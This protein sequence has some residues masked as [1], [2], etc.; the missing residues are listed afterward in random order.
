MVKAIERRNPSE[1]QSEGLQDTAIERI[2][3]ISQPTN[4]NNP[5]C[6]CIAHCSR[7]NCKLPRINPLAVIALTRYRDEL[8]SLEITRE[9]SGLVDCCNV[10]LMANQG[11]RL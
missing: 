1:Y 2:L 5:K 6:T 4:C 3:T 10:I 11:G 7:C 8:T 9:I